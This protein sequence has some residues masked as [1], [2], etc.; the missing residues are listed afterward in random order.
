MKNK[1]LIFKLNNFLTSKSLPIFIFSLSFSL[2]SLSAYL[3]DS[4]NSLAFPRIKMSLSFADLRGITYSIE[5]NKNIEL[6]RDN[7]SNCDPYERPFNYPRL[8]LDIFR[9][10][11]IDSSN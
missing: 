5:C 1:I 4:W 9:I 7:I 2:F 10:F 6:L 8:I 3:T 11:E